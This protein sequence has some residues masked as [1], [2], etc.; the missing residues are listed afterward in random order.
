MA[1]ASNIND[2]FWQSDETNLVPENQDTLWQDS[3]QDVSLEIN[4]A[5]SSD[6][7]ATG[8]AV[9]T[10]SLVL[11]PSLSSLQQTG[12][13]HFP[14]LEPS[15]TRYQLLALNSEPSISEVNTLRSLNTNQF[16]ALAGPQSN[17]AVRPNILADQNS[18]QATGS[19]PLSSHLNTSCGCFVHQGL[20]Q[21]AAQQPQETLTSGTGDFRI[22]ALDGNRKWNEPSITYSFFSGGSYYGGEKSV[23]PVSN[24]VKGFVRNI[25]RMYSSF[26]DIDFVEVA[27]SSSSYGKIRFLLADIGQ[28]YAYT[29][30]YPGNPADRDV[31]LNKKHDNSNGSDG[32]QS[33]IGK[34]GYETLIHEIGHSLGLKH[35]GNYN[36]SGG[37]TVGPY[38][39]FS[40][41]NNSNTVMTYNPAGSGSATLMPYDILA[42]Q[43]FYGTRIF[44]SATTNYTFSSV[45]SYSDGVRTVGSPTAAAKLT[46]W[47][48]SGD[49]DTLNF[50]GLGSSSGY[51]FD[52]NE[53]GWLTDTSMINTGTYQAEGDSNGTTY[54]TN[55]AGT[56]IGFGVTIENAIGSKSRDTI[57]GNGADNHYLFGNLGNDSIL[58]G[59]GNDYLLGKDEE[60][61]G[62]IPGI[63]DND[64]LRGGAGN[65]VLGGNWGYDKLFGD[66][67][68]DTLNGGDGDDTLQ[69]GNGNDTYY[70][71]SYFDVVEESANPNE[72]DNVHSTSNFTLG[73]NIEELVLNNSSTSILIGIG[74]SLNNKITSDGANILEGMA[75]NDYLVG[76]WANETL[77]GGQ[78]YDSLS[79]GDGNDVYLIKDAS[80]VYDLILDNSGTDAVYSWVNY[81]LGASLERLE[82]QG[83]ENLTGTGSYLNNLLMGNSGNNYLDGQAGIDTLIGGAGNDTYSLEQGE[84]IIQETSASPTEIDTV[85]SLYE[86]TLGENLE[87]LQ[88]IDIIPLEYVG[89]D[90][91]GAG[92]SLNN[93]L[94]G[95]NGSNF[96]SG[97]SGDDL[98]EGK[99]G[100]DTLDGGTGNDTAS[101]SSNISNEFG[102]V[103]ANLETGFAYIGYYSIAAEGYVQ[104][105]T[106]LISIENLLG[107]TW[108]DNLIGNS[109]NNIVNGDYGSDSLTG[110]DG[111]DLLEGGSDFDTLDGGGGFDTLD[112]GAGNDIY[113]VDSTG[114]IISE[115]SIIATE[116]DTVRSYVNY[117]L[118]ENLERLSLQ[119]TSN[120]NATGNTLNN[121]L[122]GTTGHNSLSGQAGNDTLLGGSG[123]DILNGGEGVDSLAGNAGNDIYLVDNTG[124]IVSET[125]TLATDID[126][127]RSYVNYT[128]GENLE[129][130]S[131][132]GTSNLNATGNSLNNLLVGNTGYNSLNGQAGN[133]TLLGGVGNDILNGGSGIDSLAGNAGNDIYLVDSTGD[134]ASETSTVATEIDT[135][136]AYTSYSLSVNLERL[137]LQGTG[138]TNATGNNA[139]NL[140]V[141][142]AGNNILIGQGGNDTL[143]GNAGNDILVGASGNDVLTGGSGNDSFNYVTG[144][145]FVSSA[146][147]IDTLTDFSRTVGNTDKIK[148]SRTTFSAGTSFASVSSDALAFTSA[149]RITLSTGTGRLFY[150]QNGAAA[151]L[152]IGGHLATLSDI[153]GKAIT[154]SNTL[155]ASDFTIVA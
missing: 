50:A 135:V 138:N 72:I 47:D 65:D 134:I 53:G 26:I 1:A 29:I 35:P 106:K 7:F 8:Q 56:R 97:N 75:G 58:G 11:P 9:Q 103:F 5:E 24:A 96:L 152:G 48:S 143:L 39:N 122:V 87:R 18:A 124:D 80:D 38:L 82:L 76:T 133:D 93:T 142:N 126:T 69:G 10:P 43:Y 17:F 20:Q 115:T 44:N 55:S 34:H 104:A 114:D 155:L 89:N 136:R 16:L 125:T 68:D 107:S 109:G 33:G 98:L 117:T 127:V 74:N 140:L 70:V 123:N 14:E 91:V 92:N 119:G 94:E 30:N 88:L 36:A 137:S 144:A 6:Q 19:A 62:P 95:N 3:Q 90:V 2:L 61:S 57:V 27:D 118:G 31:V 113:W 12:G 23:A 49:F 15:A 153:N 78:D 146:I 110:G 13:D 22:D 73:A 21:N 108:D 102:S 131:L 132:Q 148:L 45:Y 66:D 99:R 77:S 42:L 40:E 100:Y 151:G 139:S 121:L 101:F 59:D 120:L 54:F 150:N 147:G 128:L 149:A 81:T 116:I 46:L 130:L 51:Y 41:D 129:R 112:G 86:Y 83:A 111:N 63:S 105:E 141:G 154:A 28:E 85:R 71:N 67:G 64:T 25:F 32:F 84:D 52:L 37:G 145:A 79:G 4:D 60:S